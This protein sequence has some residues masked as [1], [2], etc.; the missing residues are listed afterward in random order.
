SRFT[1]SGDAVVECLNASGCCV[2]QFEQVCAV[3]SYDIE[4][5]LSK[6]NYGD[7]IAALV[8]GAATGAPGLFGVPFNI[9]LSFFL[10]FRAVQGTGLF[11]GYDVKGD[12]REL[13]LAS[14]ITITCLSPNSDDGTKNLGGLLGKMM[15]ASN[16]TALRQ[17]LSKKT[18]TEM[19]KGG[20][21][22]LLYVQIRELANKAAQKA[23][24]NAGKE[25]LEAGMFRQILEQIGRLLPQKAGKQAIPLIG[26]IVG[27]L[28][29]TYY[30]SRILHGSN[31]IYHKRF[32]F[33]KEYR[34][35]ILSETSSTLE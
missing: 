5:L 24:K 22:E 32:L 9:A 34:V 29:D 6:R 33:E 25:P 2:D 16:A 1:L 21:A 20:G 30:M 4:K 18:Y 15:F 19:A 10:F 14:Q 17:S 23:L 11:Y 7:I 8:E 28:S 3:R 35:N 12:P 13:E 27:G 26:A 31:L